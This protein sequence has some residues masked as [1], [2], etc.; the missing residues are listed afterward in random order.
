[1]KKIMISIREKDKGG[2]DL[3][4]LNLRDEIVNFLYKET[5][6]SSTKADM[7]F[8]VLLF[9]VSI[10][11]D[12]MTFAEK[13]LEDGIP[14]FKKL[15]TS[16]L[17]KKEYLKAGEYREM[18]YDH[19]LADL[20]Q[21]DVFFVLIEAVLNVQEIKR[22]FDNFF[23]KHQK[24]GEAIERIGIKYFEN[25][26]ESFKDFQSSRITDDR[27]DEE[28]HY[29]DL[30]KSVYRTVRMRNSRNLNLNLQRYTSIKSITSES[31]L[32]LTFFQHIDPQI[33]FDLWDKYHLAEYT[34]TVTRDVTYQIRS[35]VDLNVNLGDL[36][37][38]WLVYQLI[39]GRKRKEKHQAQQGF[40]ESK[41]NN[42]QAL[43]DLTLRLMESVLNTN[44]RLRKE[45]EDI[46]AQVRE[47]S[48][49]AIGVQDKEK[50]KELEKR[51]SRLENLSVETSLIDNE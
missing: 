16:F 23:K 4:L 51:I 28:G 5:V 43:E 31:P 17:H 25:L 6:A 8:F 38:A 7:Q 2:N 45:I 27:Y 48:S 40:I 10:Q 36:V 47:L 41:R 1:M 12:N 39:P 18:I 13:I 19:G 35:H 3:S 24:L 9:F 44:D 33:I 15:N 37:N 42:G 20:F 14:K 26:D 21:N 46:R 22:R 50:I 49:K 29:H 30:S 11:I 32:D 34:K